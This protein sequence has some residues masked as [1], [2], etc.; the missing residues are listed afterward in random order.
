[1]METLINAELSK[2]QLQ[3]KNT[4]YQEILNTTP[5]MSRDYSGP[6]MMRVDGDLDEFVDAVSDLINIDQ[7]DLDRKIK[8]IDANVYKNILEDPDKPGEDLA[9]VV[10]F[11]LEERTPGTTAGGNEPSNRQRRETRPQFRGVTRNEAEN[12]DGLVIHKG[13]FFDNYLSFN[14][15]ARTSAQ[16]NRMSLWFEDIMEVGRIFFARKGFVRYHFD[17]REKDSFLKSGEEG[18]HVR[19]LKFYLRTEKVYSISEKTINR[20]MISLYD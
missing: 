18:F 12:P 11:T 17:K 20:L 15:V 6:G 3:H 10:V 14:M 2:E 4:F 19:P 8:L 13:Q 9:G 7:Q 16:A 5:V 1:M